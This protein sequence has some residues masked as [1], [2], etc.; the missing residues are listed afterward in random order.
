[1]KLGPVSKCDKR[2][3]TTLKI[4]DNDVMSENCNVVVIFQIL[5]QFRA[6]QRPDSGH[7]VCNQ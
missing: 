4:F 6:G 1:M 7:R 5:G 3:K 2:N